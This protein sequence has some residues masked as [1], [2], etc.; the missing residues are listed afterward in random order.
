MKHAF[1]LFLFGSIVE[2]SACNQAPKSAGPVD[3]EPQTTQNQLPTVDWDCPLYELNAEGDTNI[4]W[5]YQD[6]EEG[7]M[8]V[9]LAEE[10]DA[11]YDRYEY[12]YDREGRLVRMKVENGPWKVRVREVTYEIDSD[13]GVRVGEGKEYAEGD[14]QFYAVREESY[15]LDDTYLYDTLTYNYS[16]VVSWDELDPDGDGVQDVIPPPVWE[17]HTFQ[18]T[19]YVETA[20]GMKPEEKWYYAGMDAQGAPLLNARVEYT[21]D[22]EG[23]LSSETTYYMGGS[24]ETKNYT[25]EGNVR[26]MQ[27]TPYSTEIKTYYKINQ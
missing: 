1:I 17:D 2:F 3:N 21:Y 15:F 9:Q 8:V 13:L 5:T 25:Y 12:Q 11:Y 4:M 23:R 26:T 7:R 20:S 24:T 14:P 18:R 16:A 22:A 19:R 10:E 6:T 27:A